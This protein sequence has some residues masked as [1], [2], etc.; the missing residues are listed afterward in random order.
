MSQTLLAAKRHEPKPDDL[1]RL[2]H[3]Q[4][5][6]DLLAISFR[7]LQAWRVR[8]GGPRFCKIGRAVRYRRRDL[9]AWVEEQGRASTSD[10][11]YAQ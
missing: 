9:I 10:Q 11:G 7:T 5:A 4:A 3:E 8:G 1:D 2:L 6:A